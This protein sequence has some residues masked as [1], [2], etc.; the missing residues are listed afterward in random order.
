MDVVLCRSRGWLC[1]LRIEDVIETFRPLPVEPVTGAPSFVRGAAIVRGAPTPVIDLAA[2]LGVCDGARGN[3]F[4]LVRA[5]GRCVALEVDE[6]VGIRWV[7]S[8]ALAAAPP[9]LGGAIQEH[10]ETLG[11]LDGQLLAVL[12]CARLLPDDPPRAAPATEA[13]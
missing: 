11:T 3:R 8:A 7:P 1:A 5:G 6:V 12:G 10:V 4:I 13:S 2:L 9:L